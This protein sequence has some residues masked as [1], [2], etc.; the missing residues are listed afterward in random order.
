[1]SAAACSIWI[2]GRIQAAGFNACGGSRHR[3]TV[4]SNVA[5]GRAGIGIVDMERALCHSTIIINNKRRDLA[6]WRG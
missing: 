2:I 5:P 6:L 4:N 1:V 3:W